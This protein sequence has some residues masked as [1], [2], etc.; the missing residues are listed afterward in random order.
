MTTALLACAVLALAPGQPSPAR[1]PGM[2]P[3]DPYLPQSLTKIVTD[4]SEAELDPKRGPDNAVSIL[5]SER[6][7]HPEGSREARALDLRIAAVKVRKRCLTSEEFAKP[8][9]LEQALST[10][11]RLDLAEPGLRPHLD[12]AL[13]VRPEAQKALGARARWK[14]PVAI[15]TRGSALELEAVRKAFASALERVGTKL[16]VVPAREAS[17]VITLGVDDVPTGESDR[18]TVKLTFSV[19]A[20]RDGHV[21][22]KNSLFRIEAA[23]DARLALASALDW[24]S[25]IGGRDLFFRFLG[26]RGFPLLLEPRGRPAA[27][28]EGEAPAQRPTDTPFDGLHGESRP[29]HESTPRRK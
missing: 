6:D 2:A 27:S 10:Y 13:A 14:L 1:T 16:E 28:H 8:A 23:H 19:E 18:A 5:A 24:A 20:I 22:F 21:V 4:A 26:E 7:R 11:A 25:R 3:I 29:A 12:R 15:L 9:R 17:L